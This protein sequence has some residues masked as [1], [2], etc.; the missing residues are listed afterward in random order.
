MMGKY[1]YNW[2]RKIG[3]NITI[4]WPIYIQNIEQV[5]T[6]EH[7][8]NSNGE[9][10]EMSVV[11][12][13]KRTCLGMAK[14]WLLSVWKYPRSNMLA[15][16]CATLEEIGVTSTITQGF[17]F[18]AKNL[19]MIPKFHFPLSSSRPKSSRT[20]WR[21]SLTSKTWND[22]KPHYHRPCKTIDPINM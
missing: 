5:H 4:F 22:G 3:E 20:E 17:V 14:E 13:T 6:I 15:K 7:L 10:L 1:I 9:T 12:N 19:E 21:A 11:S 2:K 18:D 16:W 8:A